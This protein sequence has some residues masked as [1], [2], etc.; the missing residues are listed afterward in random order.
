MQ[1]NPRTSLIKVPNWGKSNFCGSEF[2][3]WLW[4]K[5]QFYYKKL[6]SNGLKIGFLSW[7]WHFRI[8]FGLVILSRNGFEI[9][10]KRQFTTATRIFCHFYPNF[11][12]N[13]S[14]NSQKQVLLRYIPNYGK[15]NFCGFAFDLWL[16]WKSQ[17]YYKKL[18]SN[19]LNIGFLSWAWHFRICFGLVI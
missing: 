16:W 19:G 12:L 7:A 8:C 18:A 3:L 15:S 13:V 4:W 17:F 2:D 14:Y 10:L 11:D 9:F 6:A 5:S 1:K